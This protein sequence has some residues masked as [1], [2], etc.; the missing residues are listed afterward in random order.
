[1]VNHKGGKRMV[2]ERIEAKDLDNNDAINYIKSIVEEQYRQVAKNIKYIGGG[3]FGKAFLVELE[4]KSI[5]IKFLRA[6]NM[7]DKECFDLNLLANNCSV[8]IPKI[9]FER[10]ADTLIPLDCYG[11]ELV[12]GQSAFNVFK[13]LFLGTKRKKKF[14]EQVTTA[15]HE[16]HLCTNAK[17]GDTQNP[18]CDNWLDY[19]KP[20]AKAIYDTSEQLFQ[21]GKLHK[22]IIDIMRLA[23]D[24]FDTIFS[25]KVS[26]AC[27]IHGDLNITNIMVDKDYYI[28]G[29]I[30]PLNSMFADREYDLFQ[31]DNMGGKKFNLRK[32][33]IHKYGASKNCDIKCA[34][35]ALWNEVFCYIKAGTLFWSI[36]NPLIKN[37]YKNLA[38]I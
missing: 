28:T 17:F 6:E 8:K 32:T 21:E 20:F 36:M 15:L 37:M 10:K 1:M 25:E 3:S 7:C 2:V 26:T 27:L 4:S 5:V 24:K 33:Y 34:F 12:N 38:K 35:Y 19:Y 14:A 22:K 11:M 23:W 18:N 31:L 29:I 16:I 9:L 13:I 30:D